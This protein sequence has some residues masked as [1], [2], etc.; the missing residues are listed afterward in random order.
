V[1][2]QDIITPHRKKFSDKFLSS[3]VLSINKIQ[4]LNRIMISLALFREGKLAEISA[5]LVTKYQ[6]L[7]TS[8]LEKECGFDPHYKLL[9]G[10]TSF[11]PSRR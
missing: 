10:Y 9:P 7:I 5:Y 3:L 4:L 2:E 6:Y 8:R 11:D 1:V